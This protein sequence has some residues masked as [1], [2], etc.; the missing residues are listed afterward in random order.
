MLWKFFLEHHG[1]NNW[2]YL[3]RLRTERINLS[4]EQQIVFNSFGHLKTLWQAWLTEN[5]NYFI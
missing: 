2:N 5:N 3:Q 4:V 1:L